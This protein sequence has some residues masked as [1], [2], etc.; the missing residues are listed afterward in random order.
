MRWGSMH[1][2]GP[3]FL[4]F[5]GRVGFWIFVV[6]I[7]FSLSSQVFPNM[8]S[9]SPHFIP[10]PSPQGSHSLTSN[11]PNNSD[12]ATYMT[13]PSVL[14]FKN[15]ISSQRGRLQYTYLFWDC[16]KLDYYYFM[17]GQSK[18]PII[19]E[20]KN[21][22]LG[23]PQLINESEFIPIIVTKISLEHE[24]IL[25][26]L[27]CHPRLNVMEWSHPYPLCW[28]HCQGCLN[29]LTWHLTQHNGLELD[30]SIVH[31]GIGTTSQGAVPLSTEAVHNFQSSETFANEAQQHVTKQQ[32][33]P[34]KLQC[35]S[36]MKK[37]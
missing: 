16:P 29:G 23:S 2:R 20:K 6:P 9:M 1:P 3:G 17:M 10:Y 15:Y 14:L 25:N 18:M 13:W 31:N 24:Y 34:C 19:K 36:Q 12:W 7:K 8:F 35:L 37:V 33:A 32:G 27:L 26:C 11:P 30:V 5:W 4:F 22:T 21:W 28:V